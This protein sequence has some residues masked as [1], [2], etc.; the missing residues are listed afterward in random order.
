MI[1]LTYRTLF[2]DEVTL[3]EKYN[4][5]KCPNHY[6]AESVKDFKDNK[7]KLKIPIRHK[8]IDPV[9]P[10]YAIISLFDV[11]LRWS[12]NE[13][14]EFLLNFNELEQESMIFEVEDETEKQEILWPYEPSTKIDFN[15]A[16][17]PYSSYN[18]NWDCPITPEE[19]ILPIAIQA[20][21]KKYK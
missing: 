19:N 4:S 11:N 16:Y 7:S 20:G 1:N 3:T 9:V 6:V 5:L 2:S 10:D 17:N 8:I 18:D 13:K 21:E 15:N 12:K 14:G